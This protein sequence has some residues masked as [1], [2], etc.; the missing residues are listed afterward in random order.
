MKYAA[1]L[2][3][4]AF[5]MCVYPP[6]ANLAPEDL[7]PARGASVAVAPLMR[8]SAGAK[9]VVPFVFLNNSEKTINYVFYWPDENA[10]AFL[11]VSLY[12]DGVFQ[13]P[14]V[15]PVRS[16]LAKRHV[17]ALAPGKSIVDRVDISNTYGK[18]RPG[19]YE[20]RVRY[21]VGEHSWMV[22]EL[23]LT[24]MSFH[25]TIAFLEIE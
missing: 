6:D 18:L 24:P 19:T 2:G 8:F 14:L 20:L 9:V 5:A 21:D 4:A 7:K 15:T 13:K 25:R 10:L 23:G 12:R 11:H 22:K 1:V 3:I 16:P 17:R